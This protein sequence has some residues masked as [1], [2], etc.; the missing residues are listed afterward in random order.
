[1]IAHSKKILCYTTNIAILTSSLSPLYAVKDHQQIQEEDSF[2][3]G[4]S[5]ARLFV[6]EEEKVKT[7]AAVS[8]RGATTFIKDQFLRVANG[9]GSLVRT[10]DQEWDPFLASKGAQDGQSYFKEIEDMK[11]S[12]PDRRRLKDL[13][14]MVW[15]RNLSPYEYDKGLRDL[16]PYDS[17]GVLKGVRTRFQRK[18]TSSPA[19]L[20]G[21]FQKDLLVFINHPCVRDTSAGDT[22]H[23]MQPIEEF[24]DLLTYYRGVQN[25]LDYTETL[26]GL[27]RLI[28]REQKSLDLTDQQSSDLKKA[29]SAAVKKRDQKQYRELRHQQRF[30]Q[31]GF[32][33]LPFNGEEIEDGFNSSLPPVS[34]L[35][36]ED[37]VQEDELS[38][39]LSFTSVLKGLTHAAY[40]GMRYTLKHPL[41]ALTIGLASQVTAVAAFKTG[42]FGPEFQI[43]KATTWRAASSIASLT[44][45]TAFVAWGRKGAFETYDVSGRLFSG[46]G[47]PLTDEFGIKQNTTINNGNPSVVGLP[48]GDAFVTWIS[49]GNYDVYG[50]VFSAGGKPLTDEFSINQ[51]T[52]SS[53]Y[54][55]PSIASLTTGNAFVAWYGWYKTWDLYG[56]VFSADGKPLTGEFG[57]N[58][59]TSTAQLN[60]SVAGLPN[61]NAFGTWID[62]GNN[63]IS[64]RVFSADGKPLTKEFPINQNT[65]TNDGKQ[66]V[67]SLPNGNA[68]VAW[69]ASTADGSY[70][71]AYGR[72]FS[73]D[74][75]PLTEELNINQNTRLYSFSSPVVTGLTTGDALVVWD[76]QKRGYIDVG[77]YG[78]FFSADGKPLTGEFGIYT[79]TNILNQYNFPSVAGLLRGNAFV[80]WSQKQVDVYG[81]IFNN[82][83]HEQPIWKVRRP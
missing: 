8:H 53:R 26:V 11:T 56:R 60:P 22:S 43:N 54:S 63:D 12:A 46:D 67:A 52:I 23:T 18:L 41:Q 13:Q 33:E 38:E 17:E 71:D 81:C 57:I 72:V 16:E 40:K 64:G 31:A 42:G 49:A 51:K 21:A 35:A 24:K 3:V 1:M 44:N 65:T 9:I 20:N 32:Q 47:K 73:A 58:T 30:V 76:G 6:S 28:Q 68:F 62:H 37:A 82:S 29:I 4:H 36:K 75:H 48:K 34:S 14:D 80:A 69:G 70:S 55:S 74:G 7:P 15:E 25:P 79:D 19:A 27:N 2:A 5:R 78:R 10:Q 50:R 83:T 39:P 45:S 61:S 66:S 77:I 59:N